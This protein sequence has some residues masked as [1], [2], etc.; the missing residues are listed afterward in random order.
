MPGETGGTRGLCLTPTSLNIELFPFC[1][2]SHSR[3]TKL[4]SGRTSKKCSLHIT[5][6]KVILN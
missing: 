2:D 3:V 6:G 5:K 1:V 4:K